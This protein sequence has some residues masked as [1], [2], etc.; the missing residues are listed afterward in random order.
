MCDGTLSQTGP[1]GSGN[2]SIVCSVAWRFIDEP[3]PSWLSTLS[4]ADAGLLAGSALLLWAVAWVW[5]QLFHAVDDNA[6]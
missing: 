6:P 4:I 1:D 2:F 3:V 5:R